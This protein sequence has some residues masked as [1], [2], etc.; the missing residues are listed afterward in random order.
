MKDLSC[1]IVMV[2]SLFLGGC[3]LPGTEPLPMP[4]PGPVTPPATME[5]ARMELGRAIAQRVDV[6]VLIVT[7]Q[8]SYKILSQERFEGLVNEYRLQYS[9]PH[10]EDPTTGY[11]EDAR[12]Y[13]LR[14]EPR[15]A[16]GVARL[17]PPALALQY[18]YQPG[19]EYSWLI[20]VTG[21]SGNMS[22]FLVDIRRDLGFLWDGI[23]AGS[24]VA[25]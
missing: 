18:G 14:S 7:D 23:V 4:I 8:D 9:A 16:V 10:P 11:E 2:I 21:S 24:W 3:Y 17:R 13:I 12:R 6:G 25:I 22:L 5:V 15:S 1:I 20:Y 19:Q